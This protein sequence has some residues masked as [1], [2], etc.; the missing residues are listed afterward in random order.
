LK[1][2]FSERVP[3]VFGLAVSVLENTALLSS[4]GCWRRAGHYQSHLD[5]DRSNWAAAWLFRNPEFLADLRRAPCC[6]NADNSQPGNQAHYICCSEACPMMKWGVR[7]CRITKESAVIFWLPEVN[8][9]VL[10]VQAEPA[11]GRDEGV[12]LRKCSLLKAVLHRA[13]K[14]LNLLFS[15]GS[16]TLQVIV[17]GADTLD[18]RFLLQCTLRGLSEFETKPL[19][20]SRLCRL[21]K[22]N[23]LVK[24]TYPNKKRSRRWIEMLRAW[25]GAQEGACQREIAE[26]IYGKWAASEGWDVGYRYRVQ[27]LLKSAKRMMSKGYLDLLK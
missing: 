26:V 6:S 19:T 20:L 2:I 21:Y 23:K 15:D 11:K 24:A 16:H 17:Q 8:F 7:C 9:Q 27:R 4:R 10:S 14:K 18:N 5:Y 1:R 3:L 25:D 22:K 13:E 12:D